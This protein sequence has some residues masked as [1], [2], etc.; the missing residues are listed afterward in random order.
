MPAFCRN[1]ATQ[2]KESVFHLPNIPADSGYALITTIMTIR[3]VSLLCIGIYAD[4]FSAKRE[5]GHFPY[6]GKSA[7][8][9]ERPSPSRSQL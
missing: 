2:Q 6:V 9:G 3:F 7:Q 5:T 8:S 4:F 1:A